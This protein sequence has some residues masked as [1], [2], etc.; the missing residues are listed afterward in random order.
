MKTKVFSLIAMFVLGTFTV[1]AGEKTEKFK[2]KG[3]CGMCEKRI[4]KAAN[5]VKGVQ[6]ADWDKESKMMV[7]KF[8]DAK[9]GTDNIEKAIAKVG[10]DTPHH[11]AKD[12]VY[13]EL[14][15]CCKYDRT[16]EKKE[17]SHEGHQH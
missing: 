12:E 15:G 11:K 6:N 14:P 17:D 9:T 10:H 5:S 3:N 7:V 1:F 13:E 2:V 16:E 4:E 8:D